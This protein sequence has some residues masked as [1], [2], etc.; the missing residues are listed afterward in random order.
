[1]KIKTHLLIS[2]ALARKQN[3][4]IMQFSYVLLCFILSVIEYLFL[5]NIYQLPIVQF[6]LKSHKTGSSSFMKDK[7]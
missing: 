5:L 3:F 1:M 4:P 2:D 7:K 6:Y